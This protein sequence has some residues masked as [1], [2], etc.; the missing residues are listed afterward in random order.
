MSHF[1]ATLQ[2]DAL[3]EP[4]FGSLL[5][6]FAKPLFFSDHFPKPLLRSLFSLRKGVTR[7]GVIDA[8]VFGERSDR[9]SDV[10]G[11]VAGLR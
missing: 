10:R 2:N 1:L 5:S 7:Y 11:G 4:L 8:S 9:L 3:F 6:H